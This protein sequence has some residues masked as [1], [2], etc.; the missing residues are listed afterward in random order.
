[1]EKMHLQ[2][3][4]D[5]ED[6]YWWHVAKRN[7]TTTLIQRHVPANSHIVEG[8]IGAAGNLLTWQS[9]GYRVTGLD[10]MPESIEHAKTRGLIDVYQHDLH[11]PWPVAPQSADGVV[12]LDVLEHLRDPVVAMQHAARSLS[13]NGKI[14][15]TVPAYPWLFSDW[16]VRLGHFRR[17][18]PAMLKKQVSEAGLQ[19]ELLRFWNAF[20]LPAA[21][22]LRLVRKIR[23]AKSGTEFPRVSR[24]LNSCLQN[25][26]KIETKVAE[27]IGLGFGLSLVGVIRR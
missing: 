3:L 6:K 22:C 26:A 10:F 11:Q 17:Y 14:I 7:L 25:A 12:L 1:M 24:W 20:T 4:I 13:D 8:G 21:I 19:I 18:T 9:M 15:F 2:E 16:D 5:L 27:R 23:P